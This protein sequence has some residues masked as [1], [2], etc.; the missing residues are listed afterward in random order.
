[1]AYQ[2]FVD[3]ASLLNA[4][5]DSIFRDFKLSEV[6]TTLSAVLIDKEKNIAQIASAGGLPVILVHAQKQT[7]T[8]LHPKGTLL[9]LNENEVYETTQVSLDAEDALFLFTDGYVESN[10]NIDR[11]GKILAANQHTKQAQ[12]IDIVLKNEMLYTSDDDRTM[13]RIGLLGDS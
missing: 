4:L 10:A 2:Q 3:P 6:F 5:N 13:V 7:F 8:T 1:M 11:L 9:G 12:A